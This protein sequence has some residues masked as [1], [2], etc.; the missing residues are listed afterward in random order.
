MG[1]VEKQ[2]YQ[3]TLNHLKEGVTILAKKLNLSS[4]IEVMFSCGS[5]FPSPTAQGLTII[6]DGSCTVKLNMDRNFG[7]P[8]EFVIAHELRHIYQFEYIKTHDDMIAKKW[9]EEM[10]EG[11]SALTIDYNTRDSELD[12]NAFATYVYA[13]ITGRDIMTVA[14]FILYSLPE[15]VIDEIVRRAMRFTLHL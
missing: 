12:A 9:R 7:E 1:S 6:G 14:D 5:D 10:K 8:Y 2:Y 3:N 11:Y 15:N 13:K 4:N